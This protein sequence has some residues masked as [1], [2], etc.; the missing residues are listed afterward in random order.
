MI[1]AGQVIF[2]KMEEVQFGKPAAK[3]V[4]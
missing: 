1:R 2:S 3:T 4:A